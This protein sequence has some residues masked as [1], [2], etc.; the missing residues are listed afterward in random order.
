VLDTEFNC[1]QFVIVFLTLGDASQN[2]SR[3]ATL[4][5]AISYLD[6]WA[7]MIYN[8]NESKVPDVDRTLPPP[9]GCASNGMVN[10]I[11]MKY[12]TKTSVPAVVSDPKNKNW[13]QGAPPVYLNNEA[14]PHARSLDALACAVRSCCDQA[15]S[16]FAQMMKSEGTQS[17]NM[18]P[19]ATILTPT[20][21][22]VM[23]HENE[24]C[25][26]NMVL[27]AYTL[28][29]QQESSTRGRH[30]SEGH[31]MVI[32]AMDAFLENSDEDG[33][34]GFTDSQIQ[35]LLSVCNTAVANPFL[36]HHAGPT[37]HMVTNATIL[38]CHLLNAMHA[39][40]QS[41]QVEDMEVA[42]FEEVLDTFIAIRKL[43]T[44]HRR[45]L[46]VKLRCH[47]IPRPNL[48][49]TDAS[50]PI[51][52]LGETLL[53]ACRGCQGFV[54]M[55]CSPCV[56]AERARDA[57]KRMEIELQHEAQAIEM[58][59][60]DTDIDNIGAEFDLDDDALLGMISSLIQN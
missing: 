50:A 48:T 4:T 18:I 20:A 22:A 14:P 59:E 7:Y 49:S 8:G 41:G 60:L 33:G 19:Q 1:A 11:E 21:T 10:P 40:K 54:L 38:L 44:I 52:D 26:R 2:S 5:S 6:A 47:G 45:K 35:S 31:Q 58:G 27:S 42:M 37:Y 15:N 12:N 9:S 29:Q 36:L 34:T 23:H 24:L 17:D 39:M 25:S 13:I 56:A 51:V 53:C 57:T 16:R 30:H 32:S 28:M 43:L 3:T 55:A 46:P